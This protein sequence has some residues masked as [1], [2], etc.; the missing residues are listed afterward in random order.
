MKILI[1][2]RRPKLWVKFQSDIT[3]I[4]ESEIDIETIAPYLYFLGDSEVP[5]L[6]NNYVSDRMQDGAKFSYAKYNLTNITANFYLKFTDWYSFRLAKHDFNSYFGRKG[7]YR[8]RTDTHKGIVRYVRVAALPDIEPAETEAHYALFSLVFENPQG[9][10]KSLLTSNRLYTYS[11]EGWQLGMNLP[12]GVDLKYHY[13]N[14]SRFKIYNA[15][16]I[17]IDPYLQGHQLSVNY[18]FVGDRLTLRNKSTNTVYT[19]NYT[20]NGD[21]EIL[22]DGIVT[23]INSSLATDKTNYGFFKLAAKSWNDFEVSE[24]E[25]KEI[26]FDFPF[27]YLPS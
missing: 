16:D 26:T 20:S 14:V 12:N 25:L 2:T 8:I 10:G 19:L 5:A 13:Q 9:L 24:G 18:K 15:S 23:Y 7:I 27:L 6:T 3:G 4:A 11:E 21:D 1:A 22:I 17:D